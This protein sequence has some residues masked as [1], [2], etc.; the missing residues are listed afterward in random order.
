MAFSLKYNSMVGGTGT[1]RLR[2]RPLRSDC[3]HLDQVY[4]WQNHMNGTWLSRLW[5]PVCTS[6]KQGLCWLVPSLTALEILEE[7][8]E[9]NKCL[10]YFRNNIYYFLFTFLLAWWLGWVGLAYQIFT[11]QL[12]SNHICNNSS[13]EQ[14]K[15]G[16]PH[17]P[18]APQ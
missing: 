17:Y 16:L 14:H 5:A 13:A 6:M 11:L 10:L 15:S 18:L 4:C 9:Y 2:T 3:M 7:C 1:Q 8:F 12:W